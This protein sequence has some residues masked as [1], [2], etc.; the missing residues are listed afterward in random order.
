MDTNGDLIQ[1]D[2]YTYQ[3]GDLNEI[4]TR[5]PPVWVS[6]ERPFSMSWPATI[7]YSKVING[8][9]MKGTLDYEYLKVGIFGDPVALVYSG[10]LYD[11]GNQGK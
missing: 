2:V 10:N 11:A 4:G 7:S 9:T 8:I 3:G 1:I 6:V 5:V